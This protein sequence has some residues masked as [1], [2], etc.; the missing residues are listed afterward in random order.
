MKQQHPVRLFK[1]LALLAVARFEPS[2][3]QSLR[4]PRSRKAQAED[5]DLLQTLE[6]MNAGFNNVRLRL[7]EWPSELQEN[8]GGMT[9]QALLTIPKSPIGGKLPLL[10]NLHGGGLRWWEKSLQERL[11]TSAEQNIKRGYDLLELGGKAMFGL[12]PQTGVRWEAD[13]L[14]IMLDFV[15]ENFSRVDP[16]RVY[17]MGYSA[18]GGATWRW[19]NQS[20]ERFAAASPNGNRCKDKDDDI[21]KTR[22]LPIWATAGSVDGRNPS[23]TIDMG[24]RLEAAGNENV[25]IKIFEGLDHQGGGV[26]AYNQTELL[27]WM[28]EFQLPRE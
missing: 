25:V 22:N 5:D 12:D 27:D 8:L 28:L 9:E 24:E 19:I 6:E 16:D 23:G 3:G 21:E 14:D 20:G 1:I 7:M 4:S 11:E 18:G 17:V 13:S 10:I 2:S 15:L 26:A